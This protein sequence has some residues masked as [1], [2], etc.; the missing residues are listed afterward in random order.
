MT[1]G[2]W[3]DFNTD[4]CTKYEPDTN[5]YNSIDNNQSLSFSSFSPLEIA[6]S[7]RK[8]LYS[9][10]LTPEARAERRLLQRNSLETLRWT[11]RNIYYLSWDGPRISNFWPT[12]LRHFSFSGS[13]EEALSK[14]KTALSALFGF[15]AKDLFAVT[16]ISQI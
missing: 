7:A 11:M 4:T 1:I 8:K 14:D 13:W 15:P 3:L 5:R 2:R 9:T 10:E 16:T 12:S 6:H